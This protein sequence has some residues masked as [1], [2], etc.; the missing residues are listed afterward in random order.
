MEDV[1]PLLQYLFL[2]DGLMFFRLGPMARSGLHKTK[3]ESRIL[4]GPGWGSG[5]GSHSLD[6]LLRPNPFP[7]IINLQAE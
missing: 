4:N 3:N 2:T 1:T 7:Q 6:F 5:P